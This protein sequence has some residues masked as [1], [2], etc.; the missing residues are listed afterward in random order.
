MVNTICGRCGTRSHMSPVTAPNHVTPPR[1]RRGFIEGVYS[2]DECR[3]W[4]L[5]VAEAYSLEYFPEALAVYHDEHPAGVAWL[6]TGTESPEFPDVPLEIGGAA[7][8]AYRC[9]SI[10]AL[11]GA[12][13]LARAV[14]EAAAKHQGIND[15]GI[16]SKIEQLYA[17][18]HIRELLKDQALELKELSNKAAHGDSIAPI[19]PSVADEGLAIMSEVL[20]EIFEAPE[21]LRRLK[22]ARE[23][24]KQEEQQN[25]GGTP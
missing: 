16:H 11:R 19:L 4:S 6:P 17:G 24:E 23:R 12:L 14:I 25:A 20:H 10:G 9:R 15:G 7:T 22:E 21:R 2:C 3:R 5:G 18:A 13:I 8:E 1:N